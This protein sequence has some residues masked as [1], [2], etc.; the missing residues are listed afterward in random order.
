[1]I[2]ILETSTG[3]KGPRR[4]GRGAASPRNTRKAEK[5]EIERVAS[6]ECF[7]TLSRSPHGFGIRFDIVALET[8]RLSVDASSSKHAN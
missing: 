1:M 7:V 4:S 8:S 3:F 2:C 6:P 5:R